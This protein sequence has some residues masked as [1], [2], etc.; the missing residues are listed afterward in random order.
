MKPSGL[1]SVFRIVELRQE[2]AR[3]RTLIFDAPL[4]D[5]TPGQYVM[6]WLPGIGE[7]PFSLS[8]DDPLMLTIADVG[9]VSHALN[10]LSKGDPV[11]VRGPLGNGF[12]LAFRSHL[13]VAGGYGAAPLSFLARQA[14]A[15][16]HDVSICLGARTAD[17]LIMVD[18]FEEM[19]CEIYIVTE[20]GSAGQQGLVTTALEK[21]YREQ[22]V[23]VIYACGPTGMLEA[24]A[25]FARENMV[26]AEL[27]FEA[28]IRCGIGLCGSCELPEDLCTRLDLPTKGFLVCHDGP[29]AI[30]T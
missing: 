1:F 2:N 13:L 22:I 18:Q 19:G 9:S 24:V 12:E 6:V 29:V 3:T 4:K 23:E 25:A 20:D 16:H 27:S 15:Q 10:H 7:K 17:D 30:L 28:L 8:G 26:F 11:W 14:R 5:A 21:A